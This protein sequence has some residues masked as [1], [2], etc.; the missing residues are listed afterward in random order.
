[1]LTYRRWGAAIDVPRGAAKRQAADC[2]LH[3]GTDHAKYLVVQ[4][5]WMILETA[6]DPQSRQCSPQ[7]VYARVPGD[8]LLRTS[9]TT[10]GIEHEGRVPGERTAASRYDFFYIRQVAFVV[11]YWHLSTVVMNVSYV[12]EIVLLPEM[13]LR[14]GVE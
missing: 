4:N 14:I 13:C 11:T 8:V 3:S 2:A 7:P 5:A 10:G 1:M 12:F 9:R 6:G